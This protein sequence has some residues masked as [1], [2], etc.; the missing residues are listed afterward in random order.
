MRPMQTDADL[1]EF[2]YS[3]RIEFESGLKIIEW[4]AKISRDVVLSFCYFRCDMNA[5][6]IR[7]NAALRTKQRSKEAFAYA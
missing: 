6:V 2:E 1:V 3:N 5:N 4:V 7:I